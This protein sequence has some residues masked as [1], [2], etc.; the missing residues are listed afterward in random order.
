LKHAQG[1]GHDDVRAGIATHA[2]QGDRMRFGHARGNSVMVGS[3]KHAGV[4]SQR[5]ILTLVPHRFIDDLAPPIKTV[6]GYMVPTMQ[7]AGHPINRQRRRG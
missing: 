2:I 4:A 1:G 6:R 3:G 5:S 7:L